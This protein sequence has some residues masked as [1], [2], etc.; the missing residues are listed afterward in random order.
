M[1]QGKRDPPGQARSSRAGEIIQIISSARL[2]LASAY[3]TDFWNALDLIAASLAIATIAIFLESGP[4]STLEHVASIAAAFMWLRCLGIVKAL[5]QV[6][7]A[8]RRTSV[9]SGVLSEAARRRNE[10]SAERGSQQPSLNDRLAKSLQHC[11]AFIRRSFEASFFACD[12]DA[13]RIANGYIACISQS[14]PIH[15]FAHTAALSP[16]QRLSWC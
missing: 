14:P 12:S 8:E 16:S 11:P 5:N 15:P 10:G 6:S 2:G 9:A 13:E 7:S 4:S 1:L 3:F